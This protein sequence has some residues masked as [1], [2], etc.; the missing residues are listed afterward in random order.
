[1]PGYALLLLLWR[2][3]VAEE[4]KRL[5]EGSTRGRKAAAVTV[6]DVVVVD[7]AACASRRRRRPP[8][9]CSNAW[10][11]SARRRWSSAQ[12]PPPLP[13]IC[14]SPPSPPVA[15]EREREQRGGRRNWREGREK[16]HVGPIIF[17]HVNDK[18]VPHIFLILNA[19]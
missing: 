3:R 7:P 2:K 17:F 6:D 11:P 10:S 9:S 8:S 14:R 16:G 13:R 5:G 4:V 12:A 19:T 18:W 15:G 1:M